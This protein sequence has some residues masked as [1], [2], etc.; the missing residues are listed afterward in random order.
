MSDINMLVARYI[1]SWNETDPVARR[2][3]IDEIWAEDGTYTDPIAVAE[4]RDAIDATIAAVQGQF[5]GLTFAL[6]GPVDAHHD[7]VRFTWEL[8]P[9]GGEALVVGFDVAVLTPGGRIAKV[10]G[11]LDKV[12]AGV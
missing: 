5:P 3:A 7:I 4:G 9:E 12:P 8:G 6:A 11:F 2:A 10:H 1:A